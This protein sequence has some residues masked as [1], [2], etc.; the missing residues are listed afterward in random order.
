MFS[1]TNATAR[2]ASYNARAELHGESPKPACDVKLEVAMSNEILDAFAPG[3]KDALYR[4]AQ[5]DLASDQKLRFESLGALPWGAEIIGAKFL[6]AYGATG[7]AVE[8]AAVNVNNF[9]LDLQ[10]GGTVIVS[11]RVQGHPDEKSAGKLSMMVGEQV[12]VSIVPPAEKE[13]ADLAG[14]VA[15]MEHEGGKDARVH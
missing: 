4:K 3:L 2:L 10:E 14:E 9:K 13:I 1:L 8:L 12:V 6:L 11:L 15:D 5:V 7:R